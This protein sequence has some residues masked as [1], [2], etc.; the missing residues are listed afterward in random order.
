[1]GITDLAKQLDLFYNIGKERRDCNALVQCFGIKYANIIIE[2]R[3]RPEDIVAKSCL[4]GTTYATE[5]RKAIKLSKYVCLKEGNNLLDLSFSM[6][7]AH[8]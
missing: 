3:I 6:I 2:N 5:I 8:E 1:M 4:K 7:R